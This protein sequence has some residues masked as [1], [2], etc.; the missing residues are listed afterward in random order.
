VL[1]HYFNANIANNANNANNATELVAIES[2]LA[3]LA[4]TALL[5]LSFRLIRAKCES[6]DRPACYTRS[7]ISREVR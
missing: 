5:A 2:L 1:F 7:A 3:S 6:N 4:L